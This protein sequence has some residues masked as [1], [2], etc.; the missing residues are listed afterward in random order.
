MQ[1]SRLGGISFLIISDINVLYFRWQN[2]HG[3]LSYYISQTS[4]VHIIAF[5]FQSKGK[6]D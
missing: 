5:H 1:I 6:P 3:V 2:R 4:Y